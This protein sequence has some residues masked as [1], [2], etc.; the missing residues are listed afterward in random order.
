MQVRMRRLDDLRL[1][2]RTSEPDHMG[3]VVVDP[4]DGVK[5]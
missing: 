2:I 4:D 1:G 5:V 3:F